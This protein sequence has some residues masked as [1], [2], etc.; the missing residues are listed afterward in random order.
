VETIESVYALKKGTLIDLSETEVIVC[1]DS[2]EM[3]NGGWPQNAYEFNNEN[4]GNLAEGD[5]SYDG[6]FLYS[7]TAAQAG[8]GDG[9]YE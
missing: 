3:C 8:D 5:W 1:D 2:C 7:L 9:D 4:G 6:D